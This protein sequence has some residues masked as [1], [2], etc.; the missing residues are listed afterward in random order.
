M[1]VS[2]AFHKSLFWDVDP[3]KLDWERSK[4]FIIERVFT[5]GFTDDFN[6]ILNRYSEEDIKAAVLKSK[7]L[8]KKTANY[9]SLKY[10]IPRSLINVAPEYY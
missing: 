4:Q 2:E 3:E 10:K 8:D 5:R 9:F 1:K 6:T 7:T